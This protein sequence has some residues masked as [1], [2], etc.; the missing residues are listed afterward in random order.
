MDPFLNL[1]IS[2]VETAGPLM[3]TRRAVRH[4]WLHAIRSPG[5]PFSAHSSLLQRDSTTGR[6]RERSHPVP[7][8]AVADILDL[9]V[10][11]GIPERKPAVK[12]TF[13]TSDA[14]RKLS[15]S[16]LWNER[17]LDM[18]VDMSASGFEGN[19]APRLAKLLDL[20]ESL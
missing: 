18:S 5:R 8:R 11:L 4:Q 17:S 10:K 7:E 15:M 12:G 13:D 16:V 2:I 20:L 14:W 3:S 6:W 9:L 1:E 19:D